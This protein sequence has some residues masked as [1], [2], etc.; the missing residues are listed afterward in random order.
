MWMVELGGGEWFREKDSREDVTHCAD[1][2]LYDIV[3]RTDEDVGAGA[4]ERQRV[5]AARNRGW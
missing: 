4:A 5:R 1:T 2:C 3:R